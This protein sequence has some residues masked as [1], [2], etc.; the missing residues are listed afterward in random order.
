MSEKADV[1]VIGAGSAGAAAAYHC[2]R[3][4][5]GVLCLEAREL[6]EAGARWVNGVPEW[7]FAAA[8]IPVPEGVE[9]RC[10]PRQATIV[11]G[12]GPERVTISGHE[13]VD[14]DMR[15]LVGRLQA[16][17]RQEG[18]ELRGGV[19]VT[20]VRDGAVQA[21]GGEIGCRFVIDAG[22]ARA[23]GFQRRAEGRIR[24]AWCA[25]AQQVHA[26]ADPAAACRW[27]AAQGLEPAHGVSFAGAAGGFSVLGVRVE[28][29]EVSLLGGSLPALGNPGGG[30]LLREFTAAQAWIGPRLFGGQR[31]IPIGPARARLDDGNTM[32]VGD[33]AG[34]V[35][36]AHGS[37]VGAGLVAG[38]MAAESL[39]RGAGGPWQY[40]VAWQR[41]FGG[42]FAGSAFFARFS[43]TM[44]AGELAAMMRAGLLLPAAAVAAL[45]QLRPRIGGGEVA[46]LALG[47]LRERRLARR[48]LPA[49]ARIAA[50][51]RHYRRYPADPVRLPAWTA[52]LERLFGG[53]AALTA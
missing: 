42:L 25:A 11:A 38:R 46:R 2:A 45:E 18:A 3:A 30:A 4:G 27:F 36:A 37:G 22:G 44:G 15:L 6:G 13:L 39:S 19:C 8:A 43:A 35:F 14:V 28:G 50:I 7:Y 34:Q 41:R 33:A 32:Y 12:W 5:L 17:A 51:E 16:M 21:G 29:E 9:L 47:A 52:H 23:R 26:I 20:G 40:N 31:A 10:R 24:P 1:V 53:A 49:L 48:L